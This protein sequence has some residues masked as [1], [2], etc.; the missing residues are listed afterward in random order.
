MGSAR[1]TLELENR[2]NLTPAKQIKDLIR[3]NEVFVYR[4]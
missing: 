4:D 3:D 1:L 2:I